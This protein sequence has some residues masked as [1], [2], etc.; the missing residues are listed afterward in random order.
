[1]HDTVISE[2]PIAE[3]MVMVVVGMMVMVVM[4]VA[5][6]VVATMMAFITM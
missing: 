6:M 5:V 4:R 2:R 3:K 1:M